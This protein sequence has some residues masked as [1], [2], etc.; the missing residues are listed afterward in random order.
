MFSSVAT[1]FGSWT[2]CERLNARCMIIFLYTAYQL[3]ANA[4][5]HKTCEI[6]CEPVK[7]K[8][9]IHQMSKMH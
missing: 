4:Y 8:L 9:S 1:D 6:P 5:F 7:D 3:N 2:N